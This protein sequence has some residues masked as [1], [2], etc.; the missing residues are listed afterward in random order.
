MPMGKYVFNVLPVFGEGINWSDG[1]TW[2][3]K[4]GANWVFKVAEAKVLADR[5]VHSKEDAKEACRS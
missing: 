1:T 2:N 5:L 3:F 4:K